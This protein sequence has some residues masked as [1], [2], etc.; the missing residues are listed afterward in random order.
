MMLTHQEITKTLVSV[1]KKKKEILHLCAFISYFCFYCT[2]CTVFNSE[3]FKAWNRCFKLNDFKLGTRRFEFPGSKGHSQG[4]M[5]TWPAGVVAI[6]AYKWLYSPSCLGRVTLPFLQTTDSNLA[7]FSFYLSSCDW[8]C[9]PPPTSPVSFLSV[10]LVFLFYKDIIC[11][12]S[13]YLPKVYNPLV[14][15]IFTECSSHH[16]CQKT[17]IHPKGSPAHPCLVAAPQGP[18]P[19][20]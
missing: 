9:F 1:E 15:S 2:V 11:M 14:G 3:L 7:F 6:P 12:P 16:C 19:L 18:L 20:H 10:W 17:F 8:Q 4:G 5:R 13:L